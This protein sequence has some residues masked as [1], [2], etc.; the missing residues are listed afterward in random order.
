MRRLSSILVSLAVAATGLTIT[1]TAASAAGGTATIVRSTTLSPSAVANATPLRVARLEKSNSFLAVGRNLSVTGSNLYLWKIKEDLTFDSSFGVID[2]GANFSAPTSSNSNCISNN[3][4]NCSN[5]QGFIVNENADVFMI[6]FRRLLKGSG[7]STS[8]DMPIF[9]VLSGRIS[10]GAAIA[11]SRIFDNSYSSTANVA[12]WSSYSA[13]HVGKDSCTATHGATINSVPL[14]WSYLNFYQSVL[15]ADGSFLLS[16]GCDYTNDSGVTPA[17]IK[18]YDAPI[19][20]AMKPS[21]STFVLDTSFGT[22]GSVKL[23]N[24]LTECGDASPASTSDSSITSNSSTKIF[25]LASISTYARTTTIPSFYSSNPNVTSYDGCYMSGL[26]GRTLKIIAVQANGTVKKSFSYPS[27]KDFYASRWIIDA[28][29]RWN[30]TV[31]IASGMSP[32]STA[33][34]VRILPD[35]SQDTSIGTAGLKE[36]TGLPTSITVNGVS[37]SMRYSVTGIANTATGSYFVGFASSGIS[38]CNYPYSGSFTTTVYPYYFTPENGLVTTYGTNGIG[39]SY[40]YLVNNAD[41]CGGNSLAGVTYINSEGR[42]ATLRALAAINAQTSSLNYVVWDAAQGVVGGGD[43]TVSAASAAG[44]VDKK[45]YSSKLPTVAMPDSALTVLTAKQA[46]DLDIRTSTPKICIAL[47]TSVMMVNPGRCVVRIID[48]DTKKVLRTMTTTVKKAEVEEGTT[49]TTDEP[50]MFKQAS[51]ALSKTA[52]AQVAELAEAAKTASRVVV[53]GHSAAL[54]EVSQYS[55]A[56]SRD[57][58]N[59]VKAALVKAGVKVTIEVVAL[60][61]S[62]PETTKKTEAAQAKN[63]RAEVFIFP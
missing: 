26:T 15:R 48:E 52:K 33:T 45:V 17:A 21:S 31:T 32:S 51:T 2:L 4:S 54:G 23:L 34:L 41:Q 16:I 14:T 59:A 30:T 18:N 37:V 60:S 1:S 6:S 8:S 13:A 50:I 28:Q 5:V 53:I 24:P 42:P 35:G 46:Q 29:G 3:G 27:G 63:R 57:R 36:L 20:I 25:Y 39:E 19:L 38:S 22:S 56:I 40:S 12:D 10:N 11:Q 9:S 7:S 44:R 55:Y 58:A 47:T 49:L 62:Q 61:Y 43:G